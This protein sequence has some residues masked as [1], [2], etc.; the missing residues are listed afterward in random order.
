MSDIESTQGNAL[1]DKYLK[2]ETFPALPVLQRHGSSE[3]FMEMSELQTQAP[4]KSTTVSTP[5]V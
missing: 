2:L 5:P 3:K 1:I 4:R